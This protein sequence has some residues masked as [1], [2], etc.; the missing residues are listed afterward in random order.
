MIIK[1]LFE[2]SIMKDIVFLLV[3]SVVLLF[4]SIYPAM[5]IVDFIGKKR[6]SHKKNMIYIL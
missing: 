2:D 4:F 1:I 3:F 5:K 6:N